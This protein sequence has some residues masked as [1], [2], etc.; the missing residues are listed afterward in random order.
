MNDIAAKDAVW[1]VK[2][3]LTKPELKCNNVQKGKTELSTYEMCDKPSQ[4]ILID[5]KS[6][7]DYT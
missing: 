5:N 1:N 4:S 3:N 2:Q 7:R 6:H